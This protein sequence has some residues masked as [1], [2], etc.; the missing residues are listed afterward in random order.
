MCAIKGNGVVQGLVRAVRGGWLQRAKVAAEGI[1]VVLALLLSLAGCG[2][3]GRALQPP[4]DSAAPVNTATPEAV[5]LDSPAPAGVTP[6]LWAKLTGALREVLKQRGKATAAVPLT[7]ETRVADFVIVAGA[8]SV[9]QASWSFSF[10]ADYNHNGKVGADDLTPVAVFYGVDSSAS[11][12]QQAKAADGNRDNHVDLGD[13]TPLGMHFGEAVSGF[14]VQSADA[15]E[16]TA[17]WT[18]VQQLAYDPHTLRDD[19]GVQFQAVVTGALAGRYYRVVPYFAPPA[20]AVSYG[21]PSNALRYF[22]GTAGAGSWPMGGHDPR[23]TFRGDAPG[24]S[25]PRMAWMYVDDHLNVS[26][27]FTAPVL[28]N[29]GAVYASENLGVRALQPDG[30]LRWRRDLGSDACS[31]AALGPDGTLYLTNSRNEI[32]YLEALSPGGALL[33]SQVVGSAASPP[34]LAQSS[35][36]IETS[37]GFACYSL[38]GAEVWHLDIEVISGSPEFPA[39]QTADGLIVFPDRIYSFALTADGELAWR[40]GFESLAQERLAA[41]SDGGFAAPTGSG[42]YAF[43]SN[44]DLQWSASNFRCTSNIAV[45]S[46]NSLR[47]CTN[48]LTGP[49][50]C[51]LRALRR[52]GSL[53]FDITLPPAMSDNKILLDSD[54]KTY[55]LCGYRIICFDT[56]GNILWDKTLGA[57]NQSSTGCSLGADGG[58]FVMGSTGVYCL[59]DDGFSVPD[60]P[61]LSAT[62]GAYYDHVRLSWPAVEHADS[63]RIY[64]DG[65]ALPLVEVTETYYDDYSLLDGGFRSYTVS[66]VNI[67]GEGASSAPAQGRICIPPSR[68]KAPGDWAMQGHDAQHT[69]RSNVIGP[70][71]AVLKWSYA[72]VGQSASSYRFFNNPVFGNAGTGYYVY[73]AGTLVALDPEGAEAWRI[74]L[75]DGAGAPAI[76]ADGTVYCAAHQ[77]KV[78]DGQSVLDFARV[79]AIS[80]SRIVKWFYQSA[81]TAQS[82]STDAGVTLD[83]S[84]NLHCLLVTGELATLSPTGTL[85]HQGQLDAYSQWPCAPAIGPEG[86]TYL[87]SFSN[88]LRTHLWAY[89]QPGAALWDYGPYTGTT[90][91]ITG[92]PTISP[93]GRLY[94]PGLEFPWFTP[95]GDR[96]LQNAFIMFSNLALAEDGRVFFAS[97][98]ISGLGWADSAGGIN[99][100]ASAPTGDLSGLLLD[101]AGKA[102][103]V[104][105]GSGGTEGNQVYCYSSAGAL[106]WSQPV[107][108]L[109]IY[110]GL[111]LRDDGTLFVTTNDSLLAFADP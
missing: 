99:A 109:N 74:K 17:A 68:E 93:D 2:Q 78:V 105:R 92:P 49:Q 4:T 70:S 16:E 53:L 13:V 100:F 94:L 7:E 108:E 61:A 96:T 76:G 28:G 32:S 47:F 54:N 91:Y 97:S 35:L 82:I 33:W 75:G 69:Y 95:A 73:G 19:G 110:P 81:G 90:G 29:D 80:P 45:A 30:S 46:D 50:A 84:G 87:F 11:N 111:A 5:T 42:V 88:V 48:T 27:N 23:R 52:D 77:F 38:Q 6:G 40:S 14:E 36:Y 37:T 58:L 59:R 107:G 62:S 1:A 83:G 34:L 51:T 57:Q 98:T 63:Y 56:L 25:A 31:E 15:P 79:Y 72:P 22:G 85:L 24:P 60:P 71:A 102:Y 10:S 43:T 86:N 66:C 106:L 18:A 64:R 9:A 20:G 26:N 21:L 44:G 103:Y 104:T 55:V 65:A 12:W 39:T 41:F 67:L 8:D 3:H 101:A 89:D